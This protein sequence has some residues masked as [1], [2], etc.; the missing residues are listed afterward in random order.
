LNIKLLLLIITFNLMP[1]IC[2]S[3]TTGK[4]TGKVSDINTSEPLI[5]VNIMLMG[6]NFGTASDIEGDFF[7]INIPPGSYDVSVSMMG[8]KIAIIENLQISVN[9]T[10]PLPLALTPS[11]LEGDVITV[12]A[13][14]V[15]IK[16]D[17]TSSVKN[18][19]SDQI[20]IM[21]VEN[22]NQVIEMQAGIVAGHFRGGRS[23][24]VTYLIDG[25]K[26]D[27]VY[28]GSSSTIELE[29]SSIS[30]LE[31]ITGTF[32]AE[33]G[34]AMSGVVN[35]VTK[36]GRDNFESS[37]KGGYANYITSN[38]DIFPGIN[39][40]NE[41]RNHDYHFQLSGPIIKSKINFFINY[42]FEDNYNYLNG[43]YYFNPTDQ[44]DY[45]GDSSST[46]LSE[47]TGEHEMQSY[48]MNNK[49]IP[50]ID[51][52]GNYIY[53]E[54]VCINEY[55]EC[56]VFQSVCSN[57]QE[58]IPTNNPLYCE[59]ELSGVFIENYMITE[60]MSEI[61]C[62]EL[63]ISYANTT[64][65]NNPFINT[66][67]IPGLQI[68]Y[69]IGKPIN[70]FVPMNLTKN[71]SL[72]SKITFKLIENL[73]FSLL[74]S[75]NENDWSEYNHYYK[76]NPFGMPKNKSLTSLM[77]LQ[78]NYMLTPSSFIEG[79][80]SLMTNYYGH[81][82]FKNPESQNYISNNYSQGVPGF[83]TGGQNK[84]HTARETTEYTSSIK[85][86]MQLNKNHSIKMGFDYSEYNIDN[87]Q[88]LIID[89]PDSILIGIYSAYINPDSIA[90]PDDDVFNVAPSE[91]SFF[92]QDKAEYNEMVVNFGV[93][94]D[95]FDPNCYYPSNYRN[96]ANTI[97]HDSLSVSLKAK[98]LSYWSP[99]FGIAYQVANA[100]IVHFSYGHFFQMPPM[101]SMYAHNNWII[102]TGDYGTVLGNPNI[103]AEK[104]VTYEIGLWQ[105]LNSLMALELNLFYRDIYN[106]LGT[107]IWTTYN[108]VKYG[109]YSNKDYGNVRGLE[110]KYDLNY[111][112]LSIYCN[113]TLQYTRGNS[114]TPLQS[115][116][117]EGGN[118]DPVS[119]LIPMSW[120]QRHTFNITFSYN[121]DG[122]GFTTTAYYNSGTP[123]TFEPITESEAALIN[124][125]PNNDYKP[126]NYSI[127]LTTHYRLW[128]NNNFEARLSFSVYNLFDTLNDIWVYPKTGRAYSNI[129]NSTEVL[130]YR[131]TFTDVHD[132]YE[133]PAMY[134]TPRQLKLNL[135]INYK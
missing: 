129:I 14:Q 132:Q 80:H 48:C 67:F 56:Q 104:T 123:Y 90:S 94:Y 26:V 10:T 6:T 20:D 50:I 86:N 31:I 135:A 133:N 75:K 9:R 19:S 55:G 113:Y 30:E 101:Y 11:I 24:E 34:K 79:K 12:R 105:K 131:S 54:S 124:L 18:I 68:G 126:L 115:F 70:S 74:Y 61:Q 7:L 52:E 62:T 60:K 120:D 58:I 15:S 66:T 64:D 81:Y 85:L 111:D 83:S 76:Y 5:G 44:S 100:A 39:N 21:P 17:Q 110:M 1:T 125:L 130:A 38:T 57:N 73:R 109:L 116:D 59:I 87:K 106:L 13:S 119:K 128:E 82:L 40:K 89:N 114:D 25:I 71:T 63:G 3:Q 41:N 51:E 93:R 121:V 27:E 112:A 97:S 8:Y 33:Y 53:D 36:S 49:G 35:Q 107:E 69:Y 134:S 127:D 91:Y 108:Q 72:F 88:Y 32:N 65:Y 122:F 96:P 77:A 22:I 45:L 43:L 84:S 16:K 103:K 102:P 4:L 47:H 37:L 78:W 23:S 29:T 99:R 95:Y 98:K 28:G 92:I 42:R 2:L 118:K 117:R 46:W